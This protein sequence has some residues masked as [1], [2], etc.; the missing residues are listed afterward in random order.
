M[1]ERKEGMGD[2]G[3]K[4]GLYR[5]AFTRGFVVV[6]C[7]KQ[8]GNQKTLIKLCFTMSRTL[9]VK[10]L[11]FGRLRERARELLRLWRVPSSADHAQS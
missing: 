3:W 5:F 2:G 6:F 7:S 1:G 8:K 4:P 10:S 11:L 9:A